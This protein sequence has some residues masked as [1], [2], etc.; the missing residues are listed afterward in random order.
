[1]CGIHGEYI[2]LWFD[3]MLFHLVIFFL[4]TRPC[5]EETVIKSLVYVTADDQLAL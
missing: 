3:R 2:S 1:M 5:N 4:S